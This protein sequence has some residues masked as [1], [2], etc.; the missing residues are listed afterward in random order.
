MAYD[1]I[2]PHASLIATTLS[3]QHKKVVAPILQKHKILGV[4]QQK[5]RITK[6]AHSYEFKWP[7]EYKIRSGTW[8]LPGAPTSAPQVNRHRQAVLPYRHF[9]V[10]EAFDEFTMLAN[11]GPE[12]LANVY[13]TAVKSNARG[14]ALTLGKAMYTDGNAAG[15]TDQIHGFESWCSDDNAV[16]STSSKG[17]SGPNDL[18]A[19]LYTTPAYYGGAATDFPLNTCDPEAVFWSTLLLDGGYAWSGTTATMAAQWRPMM[20]FAMIYMDQLQGVQPDLWLTTSEMLRSIKDSLTADEQINIVRGPK[21][22]LMAKLGYNAISWEGVDIINEIDCPANT[23]YGI[24]FDHLELKSMQKDLFVMD[25]D[26]DPLQ[27]TKALIYKFYGNLMID[28]PAYFCKMGEL[29]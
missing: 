20:T 12:A 7:V 9:Y 3:Y 27:M 16:H 21:E 13:E 2:A 15:Y 29:Y 26:T 4:L 10:A 24:C 22:S 28:S 25:T 17:S 6:G 18:Y 1:P 14:C 5:G 23:C 19:G 8:R 11:K